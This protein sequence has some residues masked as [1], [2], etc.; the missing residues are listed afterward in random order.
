MCNQTNPN[1]LKVFTPSFFILEGSGGVVVIALASHQC[2]PGSIP[3][4]GII[5]F[6]KFL[7]SERFFP[8]YS[9]F[10]LSSK[11]YIWINLIY[12]VSS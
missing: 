5:C 12:S 6:V 9:G 7:C 3:R 11:I 8:G 10:P 1:L 2:D 4:F